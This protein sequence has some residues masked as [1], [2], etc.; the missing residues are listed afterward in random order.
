MKLLKVRK[1][2]Y[3]KIKINLPKV[4][5]HPCSPTSLDELRGRGHGLPLPS[6]TRGRRKAGLKGRSGDSKKWMRPSLIPRRDRLGSQLAPT[7][8]GGGRGADVPPHPSLA[9]G[10]PAIEG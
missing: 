6:D 7:N 9:R 5:G 2:E 8:H 4:I 1:K 10:G 3:N